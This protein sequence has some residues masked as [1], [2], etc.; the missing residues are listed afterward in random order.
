MQE[1]E[2]PKK[3]LTDALKKCLS[4]LGF[5][6]DIY[7]GMYDDPSYV[8]AVTQ[9]AN[10]EAEEE[11]DEKLKE[12]RAKFSSW[13]EKEIETYHNTDSKAALK[14]MHRA[15]EKKVQR[16]CLV[17]KYPFEKVWQKFEAAYQ[18]AMKRG[19]GEVVC[20]QCGDVS[21]D[22][23]GNRCRDCGGKKVEMASE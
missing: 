9:K 16:Q 5:S 18:S 19:L 10:L 23:A 6:A 22:K 21:N 8:E 4:M 3:S 12:E 11:A 13:A 2:A 14:A 17:V 7:M 20:E 15:N 1:D